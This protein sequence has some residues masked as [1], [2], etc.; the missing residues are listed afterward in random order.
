MRKG[1]RVAFAP[2]LEK[3]E[4]PRRA[5]R[6]AGFI[7]NIF[8]VQLRSLTVRLATSLSVFCGE[9]CAFFTIPLPS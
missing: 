2:Q 1:A 8:Y 3:S 7:R 4:N 5:I 6:V 9:P